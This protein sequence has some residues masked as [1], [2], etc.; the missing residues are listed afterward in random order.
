MFLFNLGA[1]WPQM[2]CLPEKIEEINQ[3]SLFLMALFR[4]QHLTIWLKNQIEFHFGAT[5]F[6]MI[7][8]AGTTVICFSHQK[9]ITRPIFV[10]SCVEDGRK[11]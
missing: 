8:K 9:Q 5:S 11:S 7:P 3:D 1:I 4:G 6:I 10:L 2:L